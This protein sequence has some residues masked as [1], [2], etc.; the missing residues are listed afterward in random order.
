MNNEKAELIAII[1]NLPITD[2]QKINIFISGLQAGRNTE[3]KQN[4]INKK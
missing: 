3:Q 2:L 1:N 4:E